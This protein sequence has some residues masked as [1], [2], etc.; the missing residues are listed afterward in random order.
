MA[1]ALGCTVMWGAKP[2]TASQ[3]MDKAKAR[4]EQAKSLTADYTITANGHRDKGHVLT[5][6]GRFVL[7]SSQLHTWY[8]GLTLWSYDPTMGEVNISEPSGEELGEIHPLGMLDKWRDH[9]TATLLA[10]PPKGAYVV[11]LLPRRRG[12]PYRSVV[13][14]LS[15]KTF[16]PQKVVLTTADGRVAT[17]TVESILVG[18]IIN[19]QTFRFTPSQAPG[20]KIVDLR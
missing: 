6:S 13:V 20:A 18:N 17:V 5:S 9:F 12:G 3:V 7:T 14:T 16:L 4:F 15:R 19:Q 8:D 1:V 10:N 11:K 2:L